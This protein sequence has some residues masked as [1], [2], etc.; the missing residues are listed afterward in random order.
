M[1]T[2][3]LRCFLEENFLTTNWL[4][5]PYLSMWISW[6]W[7][8]SIDCGHLSQVS[9]FARDLVHCEHSGNYSIYGVNI[10]LR[11]SIQ[12]YMYSIYFPSGLIVILSWV[13][14]S[15]HLLDFHIKAY[16][17]GFILHTFKYDSNEDDTSS[18]SIFS[19][20]QYVL[21]SEVIPWACDF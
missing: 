7:G 2:T 5:D 13:R 6:G 16:F 12:P 15:N 10:A 14:H 20:H 18:G 1:A 8:T 3:Q 17:Y 4:R 19:S 11:R 21:F 9:N